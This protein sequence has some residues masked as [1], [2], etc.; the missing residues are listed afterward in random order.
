MLYRL[1]RILYIYYALG[2]IIYSNWPLVDSFKGSALPLLI[3]YYLEKG[4]LF[5]LF[6]DDYIVSRKI[7]NKIF[8]FFYYNYF[9]RIK[10][11]KINL[12]LLKTILF[13]DYII[14]LDFKLLIGIIHLLTKHRKRFNR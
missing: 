9:L 4:I 6:I 3:G 13:A 10:F 1:K 14:L 12:S 5:N 2:D 7:F 11:R 8:N